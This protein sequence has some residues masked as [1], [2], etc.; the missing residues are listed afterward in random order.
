MALVQIQENNAP[1]IGPGKWRV[2]LFKSLPWLK[3]LVK[4]RSFQFLVTL[5]TLIGFFAF[6]LAGI[7]GSPVGSHNIIVVFVWILWW[8]VLITAL[9]PF[10]SRVWCTVCPLPT[11]GE[12]MQRRALVT[13]RTGNTPGTRNQLYGQ[14]R[15]WP[16][17]LSNIW[18]QNI[19]FM[20]LATF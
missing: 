3:R 1:P 7:Y 8:F 15:R 13:V 5:P 20:C 4:M 11:M 10:G 9:V 16:K 18:M 17:K 2:D 12:W 19:G 6:L 14:L